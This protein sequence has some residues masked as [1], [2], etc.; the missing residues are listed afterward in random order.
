MGDAPRL[1]WSLCDSNSAMIA[2]AHYLCLFPT[3]AQKAFSSQIRL[4][5]TREHV[6]S[7]FQAKESLVCVKDKGSLEQLMGCITQGIREA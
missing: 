1:L 7:E 4:L 3:C 5:Q 6:W 2:L